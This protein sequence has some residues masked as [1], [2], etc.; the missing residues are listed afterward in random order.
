MFFHLYRVL[1]SFIYWSF[2]FT[3]TILLLSL[4][5]AQFSVSFEEQKKIAHI[6]VAKTRMSLLQ[7]IYKLFPKFLLKVRINYLIYKKLRH[8]SV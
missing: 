1:A 6:A 4:L 5:V 7:K 2:I 8:K 3:V